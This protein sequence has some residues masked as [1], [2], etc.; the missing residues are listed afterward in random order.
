MT[1]LPSKKEIEE[2]IERDRNL[3]EQ[4]HLATRAF[5]L[6]E[7]YHL[8]RKIICMT[9]G[10]TESSITRAKNS[11]LAGRNVGRRGSPQRLSDLD[12][13]ILSS[14][15]SDL[16]ELNVIVTFNILLLLVCTLFFSILSLF[17]IRRIISYNNIKDLA[18][19]RKIQLRKDG[20]KV[21]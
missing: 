9:L 1:K 6:H 12:E 8:P 14:W 4:I 5:L 2:I 21:I 10:C 20:S 18:K 7:K 3:L 17:H 16:L 13:K 11:L 15:I 19:N